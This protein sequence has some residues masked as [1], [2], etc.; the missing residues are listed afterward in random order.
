MTYGTNS[1][2]YIKGGLHMGTDTKKDNASSTMV[3]SITLSR[4]FGI[5]DRRVRQ[6][7]EEKVLVTVAKNKY[8]LMDSVRRYCNYLKT[9]NES[10]SNKSPDKINLETERALHEKA[11]REKAELLVKVMKGELHKAEDIELVMTDMITRA[12][13]KLLALPSK[14]APQIVKITDAGKIQNLI[15]S[16]IEEALFELADYNADL[17]KNDN[18]LGD[19]DE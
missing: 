2:K 13:V 10:N 12:K 6:L 1:L 14:I 18:V 8:D 19:E 15:Q 5:T 17:F 16:I 3:N 9:A 7:T 11:K 4:F